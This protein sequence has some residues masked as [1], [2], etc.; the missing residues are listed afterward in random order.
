MRVKIPGKPMLSVVIP[1]IADF[2]LSR[3]ID[4]AVFRWR[5]WMVDNADG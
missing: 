5:C 2:G 1:G 3:A 4:N